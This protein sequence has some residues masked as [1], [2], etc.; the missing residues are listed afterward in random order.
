MFVS[1]RQRSATE[2]LFGT[3]SVWIVTNDHFLCSWLQLCLKK[4]AYLSNSVALTKIAD[5]ERHTPLLWPSHYRV[6]FNEIVRV[7]S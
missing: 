5:K 6:C 4:H 7:F 3:I 2:R 1:D